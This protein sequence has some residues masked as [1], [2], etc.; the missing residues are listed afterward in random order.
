MADATAQP[1]DTP[2]KNGEKETR[3][4]STIQ[5]P[6]SDLSDA[7]GVAKGIMSCGG[8]PVDADQLAGAMGQ[9]P[10]SGSF[11]LKIATA[12]TFG[13]IE[14]VQGKYLLTEIGFAIADST[15]EKAAKVD[16][17]LKV[18]LYKK[19]YEEFRNRQLP[20]RPAALE[21]AF[22]GFGVAPKQKDRARI[23]FDK[24]AQQAGFFDQGGRDRLIRP[25]GGTS[26]GA[27]ESRDQPTP[28]DASNTQDR[29]RNGYRGGSG[30]GSGGNRHP[31]IEGLLE[32]LPQPD[33][34]WAIEGRA[35]WLE[36]AS[37]VFK[38]IYQGDGRI[39]ITAEG[40]NDVR[41]TNSG[42]G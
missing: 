16:A 31:F 42:R 22:V 40:P 6:Y 41:Q 35:A 8:V 34:V 21:H 27:Q 5:F 25:L 26:T 17:F 9:T 18:P 30:G 36:A 15:K 11:R 12:R 39:T 33:T 20:P 28:D 37:S 14:T 13:V 7:I 32:R 2:P 38:L 19:V 4:L 29:N 3:D 10:G 1:G 24:S 23:A